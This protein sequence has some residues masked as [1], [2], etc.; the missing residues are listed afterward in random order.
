MKNFKY[1][2]LAALLTIGAACS[3]TNEEPDT[4]DGTLAAPEVVLTAG[5]SSI[6]AEWAPVKG[7]EGYRCEV[8]YISGG[9]NVDVLKTNTTETSFTVSALRPNTTYTVRVAA[10]KDG[11]ASPNW[12]MA[13]KEFGKINVSFDVTPYETYNTTTG[14]I[15]YVARVHSTDDETWYWIA[16]VTYSQMADAKL[17]MEEEISD[18]LEAGETW[19]TLVEAGYIVKGDAESTFAFMGQDEY[20]FT[21][22]ALEHIGDQINV[23]SDIALSYPFYAENYDATYSHEC[24]YDDY[25]GDWV[26][27]PYDKSSYS[28]ANGWELAEPE[29]FEVKISAK[30]KGKSLKMTGWGGSRNK[31]SSSPIVLD[32]AEPDAN[33]FEHFTISVPQDITTSDGVNWAYTSWISLTTTDAD[34]NE[35][36]QSYSPYDYDF[37][38]LAKQVNGLGWGLAFRGYVANANRTVIKILANEYKHDGLNAYI[39]SL[40]VCGMDADGKYNVNNPAYSLNG[41]RG[42]I[43]NAMY[44]LVRK[45]V[46]DGLELA[47]PDVTANASASSA[48]PASRKAAYKRQNRR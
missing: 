36:V 35:T 13:D 45:D 33:T 4:D 37:D 46:A 6:T 31:Y 18:A 27:M 26:V 43:P 22:G 25:L 47:A 2:L 11:K 48:A 17:W 44:Y 5:N 15:D 30:E 23:V 7:A 19:E 29:T 9:R 1:M 21:A 8:T 24:S 10:T 12:F 40:W 16:A 28:S 39:Q 3:K 42:D 41:D 14:H 38:A 20:M 32:Y 34:G